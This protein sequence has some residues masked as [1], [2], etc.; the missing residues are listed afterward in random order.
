MRTRAQRD[1]I[2]WANPEG[3]VVLKVVTD[4]EEELHVVMSSGM[5]RLVGTRLR[6]ASEEAE[7]LLH[8][9]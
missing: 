3:N 1:A 2:C 4:Q 6:R 5:A 9:Q 7:E 8:G